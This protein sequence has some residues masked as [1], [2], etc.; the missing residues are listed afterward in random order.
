MLNIAIAVVAYNRTDSVQKLLCS[1]LKAYYS[2]PAP[3]IIS[4][5]KSNTNDVEHL[6]DELEWPYGE[7]IVV[8][9]DENLGLRKHI[10]SIGDYTKKYDGVIVLED[11]LE[12][13][14]SFY[15]FAL[16]AVEKY[17]DDDRIAGISLY[18]FP[19]N[20]HVSLPFIPE[21]N[22]FD[23]FLF[24][25]AQSWGQVWMT[26][27]WGSFINWYENNSKEFSDQPH[28][29]YSICH[30]GKNSWLK[31]HIKYCIEQ[32]KY[33]VYPYTSLTYCSGAAGVHS[34]EVNNYIQGTVLR[35]NMFNFRLPDYDSAIK[36]DG[37]Y[38]RVGLDYNLGLDD[39][40]FDLNGSKGN[41][42]N[43]RYWLTTKRAPYKV[44]RSYGLRYLPMEQNV[45]CNVSGEAIF[46]YDT[47]TK[48]R[49]P[50][51][52]F[53]PVISYYKFNSLFSYMLERG[54]VSSSFQL[55]RYILHKII[56]RIKLL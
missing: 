39:V 5:D 44:V 45:V 4:I 12:V 49:E 3:L 37:F 11:D 34:S 36:Y 15:N 6:A 19:L 14:P 21:K 29:P 40:C 18:T 35:G 38:E 41:R 55:L 7:K 53:L 48:G 46:L 51:N 27:A 47:W 17:K 8:K 2:Q 9:H 54:F 32:D 10:L 56:R 31:Y 22:Q 1:L 50:K 25:N 43:H 23:A 28:L 20:L 42:M 13:S 52:N 30:W 24:Q 26:K 16:E 33:F